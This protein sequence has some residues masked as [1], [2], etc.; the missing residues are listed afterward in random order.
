MV[1]V[2]ATPNAGSAIWALVALLVVAEAA[3]LLL[4][5]QDRSAPAKGLTEDDCRAVRSILEG[6]R[7]DVAGLLGI[8]KSRCRANI[9]GEISGARR[10]QI[11]DHLMA[12]MGDVV[13][14]EISVP[15][16]K[17][18]VGI[19]WAI[20]NS[21]IVV[22]PPQGDDSLSPEEASRVHPDLKWIISV[23]IRVDGSA[24]WVVNVDGK[25]QRAEREL[26]PA[27]RVVQGAVSQLVPFAKKA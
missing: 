17:G 23:P 14:W 2:A 4:H 5:R 11:V 22:L 21:K 13:E 8:D 3:A 26:E 25:E 15:I 19:A 16:G 18:A 9:F 24:K 10:L 20:G 12:N 27:V 7:T 1:Q 6:L